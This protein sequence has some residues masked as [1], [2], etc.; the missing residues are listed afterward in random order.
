MKKKKK[1][2]ELY[3][4]QASG[5]G[6]ALIAATDLDTHADIGSAWQLTIDRKTVIKWV[7]DSC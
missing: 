2:T 4:F 1:S 5:A 3:A 6:M 7:S